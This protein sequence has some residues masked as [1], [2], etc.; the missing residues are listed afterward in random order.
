LARSE[1]R[2]GVVLGSLDFQGVTH[3][4]VLRVSRGAPHRVE[5][6]A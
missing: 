4:G 6:L 2:K 3:L 5:L 1:A